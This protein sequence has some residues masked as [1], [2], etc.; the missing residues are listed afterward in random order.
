MEALREWLLAVLAVSFLVA[1]AQSVMPEGPIKQVGRLVCG[2]L[3]FLAVARPILGIQYNTLSA[4]LRDAANEVTQEQTELE[5]TKNQMT[6]AII[7]QEMDAY[8]EDKRTELGLACQ[9]EV[10]WDWSG[11]VPTPC[12]ATVT[13]SLT[14]AERQSLTQVLTQDLGL[15]TDA[16]HYDTSNEEA[17]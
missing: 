3:L 10:I 7:A 2:L 9:V 14:E 1:A 12:G 5:E 16:I 13:G 4:L 17:P 11:T 6:G 8:I 15:E